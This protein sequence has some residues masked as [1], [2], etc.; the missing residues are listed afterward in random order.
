[1]DIIGALVDFI[2]GLI[3]SWG[4]PGIFF[5]MGLESACMPIPSE[6]VM[7]FAGYL[8]S[9]GEMEMWII[10]L[11][12]SLGC[13]F[14]SIISYVAG[15]YAGRPLILKYGKYFLITEKHLVQA[16]DWFQKWGP[17]ATFIARLLPVVRTVI[18]LPAGVAKMD[19]RK[20]TLYSFVGS[21]PWNFLLAYT[22]YILGSEWETIKGYYREFEYALA[23]VG[24]AAVVFYIW[25]LRKSK[26]EVITKPGESAAPD[27]SKAE[28]ETKGA[29][30]GGHP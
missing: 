12:G 29:G 8:A 20:F 22:G 30:E 28:P 2:L 14:G 25:H 18:S 19:F 4:Y 24:I 21:V 5:L 23:I 1:M 10:V 16:E 6:V 9:Q 11:V 27:G 3:S 15:Y 26:S 7:P 13:T 17:K